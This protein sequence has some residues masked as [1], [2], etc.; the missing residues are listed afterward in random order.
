MNY[1]VNYLHNSDVGLIRPLR[2]LNSLANEITISTNISSPSSSASSTS[3]T[4]ST[5]RRMH[6]RSDSKI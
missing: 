5:L 3:T 2:N 1:F 6:W 4:A